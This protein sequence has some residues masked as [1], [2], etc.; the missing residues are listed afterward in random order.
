[1]QRI[2]QAPQEAW[3][4]LKSM[5]LFS[6]TVLIAVLSLNAC[7]DVPL[8]TETG[9]KQVQ[10]A[11]QGS[12]DSS[13]S[14]PIA[15]AP[16]VPVK[17]DPNTSP[18]RPT[19]VV[20]NPIPPTPV[21]PEPELRKPVV[22]EPVVPEPV[23]PEPV[24]TTPVTPAPIVPVP[25]NPAPISPPPTTNQVQP[26]LNA[27]AQTALELVNAARSTAQNCGGTIYPAV[28]PLTW[29]PKLEAAARVLNQ[30]MILKQ[31]FAHVSPENS[32]PVTR[33]TAQG[34]DYAAI[35]ENIAVGSLGSN[36]ASLSGAIRGWIESPGHCK[37]MM[38]PNFTEMG[39]ASA[40]GPWGKYDAVYWTQ[41][42]GRPR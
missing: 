26:N 25:V 19:P 14:A 42:L 9:T 4:T 6:V 16:A 7:N 29:N 35:G 1:M 28:G 30:D 5:R 33:V 13:S 8:L 39:L 17:P 11:P 32:T 37:N 15:A 41:E 22:P 31:Y 27:E 12:A 2:S 40:S 23:V 18:V 3:F 20:Q 36:L 38:N 21:P 24:V 10:D 34:Y